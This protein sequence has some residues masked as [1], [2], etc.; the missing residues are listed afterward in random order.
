MHAHTEWRL[1]QIAAFIVAVL[2]FAVGTTAATCSY[3]GEHP[4]E[5]EDL[6]EGCGLHLVETTNH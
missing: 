2:L 3:C 4:R 1:F 5:F 6:C